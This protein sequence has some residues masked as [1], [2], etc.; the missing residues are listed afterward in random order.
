MV[1]YMKNKKKDLLEKE[2]VFP[3]KTKNR[4][5]YF[6][7]LN[8]IAILA[9][10]IMHCNGIVHGNPEIRAWGTS[11]FIDCIMY[12]AVPIFFMLS[13]ATLMNYRK[14]YNTKKFFEK[15]L[16]K[17][18]IPFLFWAIIMFIWKYS[19]KQINF[20]NFKITTFI[21]GFFSNQEESTFL[22]MFDI[23]GIYLT[24]PLV[25]LLVRD[26]YRKT[27]WFT[28]LLFLIFN[29]TLPNVL[30]LFGITFNQSLS[31][32]VGGYIIYVLLGY[33]LSTEEI[34]KKQS[35]IIYIAALIGLCYRFF[36]TYFMSKAEGIV[37]RITWGYTSWHCILLAIAVFIFIKGLNINRIAENKKISKIITEISSCSFGIYLIHFIIRYYTIMFLK[38]DVYSWQFRTLGALFIYNYSCN[39]MGNEKNTF[40]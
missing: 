34:T 10:V 22:F 3:I 39:C 40:N 36:T 7:I 2:E 25:S 32:Q 20:E 27:L 18:L 21:N 11:L 13:G 9:V 12:W 23:L 30:P 35:I 15:R 17:V 19:T 37:V 1:T 5:L 14:K 16:K 8:I 6:D 28:V 29:A 33:L 26:E 38:L 4:V 24:M 31:V